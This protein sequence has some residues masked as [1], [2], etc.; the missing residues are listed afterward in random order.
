MCSTQADRSSVAHLVR[1]KEAKDR[2]DIKLGRRID[3]FVQVGQPLDATLSV[4]SLLEPS[5]RTSSSG[6]SSSAQ[7]STAETR[8][9]II[10]SLSNFDSSP[11]SSVEST[12]LRIVPIPPTGDQ[13]LRQRWV[14]FGS[15]T[16]S[17]LTEEKGIPVFAN[18]DM[19]MNG[20]E[21]EGKKHKKKKK[22]RLYYRIRE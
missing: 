22:K 3:G 16:T 12:R 18:E 14:P 13:Q 21:T 5:R 10:A 8:A 1:L 6:A 9:A 15:T 20:A 19:E 2:K 17:P 4:L 11:S 7:V